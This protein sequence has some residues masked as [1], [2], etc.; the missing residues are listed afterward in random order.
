MA[1]RKK[2]PCRFDIEICFMSGYVDKVLIVF[3]LAAASIR[4]ILEAFDARKICFAVFCRQPDAIMDKCS[5]MLVVVREY[6][7]RLG[8]QDVIMF[9]VE[10]DGMQSA[11]FLT[12]VIRLHLILDDVLIV[13]T[14]VAYDDGCVCLDVL[15][16]L[17]E[18]FPLLLCSEGMGC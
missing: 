7:E 10:G 3:I 17:F 2:I 13:L 9:V 14:E 11:I 6:A 1:G 5:I 4:E 15:L 12:P 18:V 8:G 16:S